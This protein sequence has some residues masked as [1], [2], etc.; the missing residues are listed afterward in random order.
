MAQ[1]HTLR[2]GLYALLTGETLT[3]AQ[4][5]E[6]GETPANF[7]RVGDAALN[8][9]TQAYEAV[10]ASPPC[11]L[12]SSEYARSQGFDFGLIGTLKE[13][14]EVA[15]TVPLA[16]EARDDAKARYVL[17]INVNGHATGFRLQ[18][19]SRPV[20]PLPRIAPARPVPAWARIAD[21]VV[22][23]GIA[24]VVLFF[25]IRVGVGLL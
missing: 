14:V 23:V 13:D 12:T 4:M 22:Y 20:R 17:S 16:T 24:G 21:R 1:P 18:T 6:R 2:P 9:V 25:C 8:V 5:S 10:H 19:G 3:A 15:Y 11:A 7:T